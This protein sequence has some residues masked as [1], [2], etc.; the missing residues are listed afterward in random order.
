VQCDLAAWRNEDS[1][2]R[3]AA[4]H[5][6]RRCERRWKLT[7]GMVSHEAPPLARETAVSVAPRRSEGQGTMHA[8]RRGMDTER[9]GGDRAL[10]DAMQD[11]GAA[12]R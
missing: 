3:S 11:G 8:Q 4:A 12:W 2:L 9:R 10:C 1:S 5:G 6:A 7:N